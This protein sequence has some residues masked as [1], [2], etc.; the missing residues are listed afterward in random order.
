MAEEHVGAESAE[1]RTAYEPP[2]PRDVPEG[3]TAD[4][5]V[6]IP[7]TAGSTSLEP[8]LPTRDVMRTVESSELFPPGGSLGDSSQLTLR[9]EPGQVIFDKY[10][11]M[12]LL[13]Q[14]GMGTVWLVRHRD[15]DVDRALKM[16]VAGIATDASAR[17]RLKRE[18]RVMALF[19]HPNAVAVH[20]AR[21]TDDAA[22]I[23]MEYVRGQPINALLDAGAPMPLD[24]TG[25][26][27]TQLCDVLQVAHEHGIVH[28]DLKPSNMM[29]VDGRPP[30]KEH[31]KV[32]DFGIAKLL[33]A[34]Q[35]DHDDVRTRTGMFVGTAP[36][37]SPDQFFIGSV[38][39]RSDLYSVGVMLYEFLTGQRPFIGPKTLY[40]HLHTPPPP[41][42]ARNPSATV[43]P[44]VERVVMRCLAKN[45]ND[46]PASARELAQEFLGALAASGTE[47]GAQTTLKD[48]GEAGG[49]LKKAPLE[50]SEL[51]TPMPGVA[52]PDS[53]RAGGWSTASVR[54]AALAAIVLCLGVVSFVAGFVRQKPEVAPDSAGTRGQDL[55]RPMPNQSKHEAPAVKDLIVGGGKAESPQAAHRFPPEGFEAEASVQL[56]NGL[57]SVL[58][59]HD[60]RARFRLIEGGTFLMGAPARTGTETA[61]KAE[62]D[63]ADDQPAHKVRVSAFFLQET[64]VTNAQVLEYLR[65][66]N[67]GRQDWPEN[68]RKAWDTLLITAALKE[69]DARRYPAV[70]ISQ[71][72][73]KDLATWA[74]G[75]LPTEAEWEYASRS[76]GQARVYVWGNSPEPSGR[77]ANIDTLGQSEPPTAPIGSYPDDKTEQGI[78]DL[79]G[80]VREWCLDAWQPYT[81]SDETRLNPLVLRSSEAQAYVIR[82]GS[83]STDIE[84]ART[85]FRS[86]FKEDYHTSIDLGFRIVIEIPIDLATDRP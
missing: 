26:I 71:V 42:A 38:D 57:P 8:T 68:F 50:D 86:D 29:L 63:V 2:P 23:E 20:D 51:A 30:G 27:L 59:R 56:I 81:A 41:F 43:P 39:G 22:F 80:N 46:R 7:L 18:A 34:D 14:G 28:R 31:L 54:W 75:R 25:R 66:K 79:T 10:L 15:L 61:A 72:M 11:V 55:S 60:D 44:E 24:W 19:S 84:H 62:T 17:A 45:P 77:L 69:Q 47:V 4:D 76:R 5:A 64:E 35:V 1:E 3:P 67:I 53:P 74:G 70:G 52:L 78:S 40:D 6:S 9:L 85:T 58:I 13:G 49:A 73:A 16:I 12:R 21:M 65:F 33:G 82:G 36:Y 83:F 48:R 37:A 32:L